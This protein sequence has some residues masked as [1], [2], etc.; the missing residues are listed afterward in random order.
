MSIKKT[1]QELML[2]IKALNCFK[3]KVCAI[4]PISIGYSHQCFKVTVKREIGLSCYFAKSLNDDKTVNNEVLASTL[5]ASYTLS[6]KIIYSSPNW[7]VTAFIFGNMLSKPN[8]TLAQ[9]IECAVTSM[10]A[11]HQLPLLESMTSL[12][13]DSLIHELIVQS[14][15]NNHQKKQIVNFV[16]KHLTVNRSG[17]EVLCHGDLNFSNI[18][19]DEANKCWLVDLEC[20]VKS[21]V[22][23]DLAMFIA[24]NELTLAQQPSVIAYYQQIS[25]VTINEALLKNYL[26]CCYIINGLWYL[27]HALSKDNNSTYLNKASAQFQY[28]DA[29]T[30]YP[31]KF[32]LLLSS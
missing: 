31:E 21:E 26:G 11:F 8:F 17:N 20:V 1:Q 10:S 32:S 22:E 13:I 14:E 18:L 19:I 7:L 12:S 28:F 27:N 23:Y 5:A 24:V 2:S 30:I 9:K 16:Q 29:L 3:G 6:P 15:L 25:D 4:E